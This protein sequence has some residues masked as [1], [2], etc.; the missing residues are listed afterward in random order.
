ML[1]ARLILLSIAPG[2]RVDKTRS[3]DR[4][5]ARRYAMRGAR[6]VTDANIRERW[7]SMHITT[8]SARRERGV[9]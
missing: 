4:F 3:T 2:R 1:S 9:A 7:R 5:S 6:T 8:R